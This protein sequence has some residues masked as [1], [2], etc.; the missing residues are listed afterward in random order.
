MTEE[1]EQLTSAA[2]QRDLDR[3]FLAALRKLESQ[4]P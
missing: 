3:K 2:A 1:R 4:L